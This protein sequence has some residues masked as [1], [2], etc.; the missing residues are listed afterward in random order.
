MR[1][2]FV[3][4]LAGGT[5]RITPRLQIVASPKIENLD[6]PNEDA[7]AIDLEDSNLFALN[8]FAGYDRWEDSSRATYGIDYDL[9]LPGF[10]ISA[11]VGQSYRLDN[12]ATIL[13]SGTGLSD[14]FSDIVG[15][16][17]VRFRDFVSLTHRYRLDKDG[18]AVRR[19]EV[20]AT[21]GSRDTY[22]L[23]GYLR[24]NRDI[25]DL[26]DLQDRE[27]IRVGGRVQFARF[28]SAFASGLIDLTDR[29]DDVFSLADGFDPIRHRLGVQ[30]EDD[31][32]TLGVTWRQDYRTTGDARRG[33]SYLL[34]LAFKN[35]GR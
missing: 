15:R 2:P 35:L 7:R 12:R 13:P 11:N 20:D 22:L 25:V 9:D 28:W 3:G 6:L 8:R 1:W 18:L 5:Q 30:Y 16:T 19:N 31:C 21:V 17:T 26:E 14:R 10:S 4:A 29:T 23:V 32:L 24:L 27:E 34:T 33:S